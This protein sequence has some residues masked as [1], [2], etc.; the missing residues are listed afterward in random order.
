[1]LPYSTPVLSKNEFVNPNLTL[2]RGKLNPKSPLSENRTL[3]FFG[4]EVQR[5]LGERGVRSTK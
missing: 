3:A 1:M 4:G 5:I 2:P